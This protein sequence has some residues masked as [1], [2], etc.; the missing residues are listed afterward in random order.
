VSTSVSDLRARPGLLALGADAAD[1]ITVR[2]QMPELWDTIA[3]RCAADTSV[4]AL[5]RAALDAFGQ[6]HHPPVDFVV[7]LRGFEVLDEQAPVTVAGAREGS[8]FLLTY[9]HRRPV[10]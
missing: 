3:V 6:H 7:K 8:T 2:V 10:R 5:K 4:L 1:A 9:R